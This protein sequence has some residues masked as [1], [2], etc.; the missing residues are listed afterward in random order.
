M[1]LLSQELVLLFM[2][3]VVSKEGRAGMK[4]LV[5]RYGLLKHAKDSGFPFYSAL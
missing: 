3:V 1:C 4:S 2:N 5:E